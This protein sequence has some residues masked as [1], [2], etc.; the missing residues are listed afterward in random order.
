MYVWVSIVFEMYGLI[1]IVY[2]V[3]NVIYFVVNYDKV[4]VSFYCIYFYFIGK[5]EGI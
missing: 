4:F 2:E 1:F 5:N 3:L